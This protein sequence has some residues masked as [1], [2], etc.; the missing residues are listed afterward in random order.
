M[1]NGKADELVGKL[2][3]ISVIVS[4]NPR[5]RRIPTSRSVEPGGGIRE[6]RLAGFLLREMLGEFS[7]STV[8]VNAINIAWL[9]R[10]KMF[11]RSGQLD[12][13]FRLSGRDS[14]I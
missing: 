5:C 4:G 8:V 3:R 10:E 9:W 12:A 1:G 11:L 2:K 6:R 13:G 14:G 7:S